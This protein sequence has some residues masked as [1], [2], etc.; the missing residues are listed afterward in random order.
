MKLP[1]SFQP[2]RCLRA[3][4]EPLRWKRTRLGAFLAVTLLSGA[5][6]SAIFATYA[7]T[8]VAQVIG[9]A[10]TVN[11][12]IISVYDLEQRLDF[13]IKTTSLPNTNESRRRI[14]NDIL[15]A[16]V[17]ERLQMQEAKRLNIVVT[18]E[19]L[20]SAR[21]QLER[22]NNLRPGTL[23]DYLSSQGLSE[24]T[25]NTQVRA[26]ISWGKVVRRRLLPRVSISDE[27]VDD[28]VKELRAKLGTEQ[29]RVAEIYLAAD[30]PDQMENVRRL[31]QRLVDQLRTG[32]R[33][34]AI[35]QQ[36][37]KSATAAQGGDMGWVS[38]GELPAELEAALD[39]MQEGDV[40]EPIEVV[41]GYYVLMLRQKRKLGEV[42]PLDTQLA[43]VELLLPE[44]QSAGTQANEQVAEVRALTQDVRGC[45]KLLDLGSRNPRVRSGDIGRIRLGDM[46]ELIRGRLASLEN[47]VPS[48]PFRTPDGV[49]VL[50]ICERQEARA[51]LP[52][53]DDIRE[54]LGQQRL[55]LLSRKYL[56]DLRRNATIELR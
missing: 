7:P 33:F 12:E 4:W 49:R 53:A 30:A 51:D 52:T 19:E 54:R 5:S 36:F 55:E 40:S 38:S 18:E 48:A 10:A 27:E 23:S 28:V 1:D 43:L 9:I 32:A 22:Q 47:G 26:E 20:G 41:G 34:P 35:A 45:A 29:R 13:V 37:S 42:N 16:I 8:A 6:L 31:A 15:R 21:A 50:M 44:P 24:G 25:L 17:D 2:E 46:P 3:A 56:R 11:D 39:R 14:R